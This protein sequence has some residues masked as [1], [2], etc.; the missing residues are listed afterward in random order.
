MLPLLWRANEP[1]EEK[2]GNR[3]TSP[4]NVILCVL[5][6]PLPSALDPRDLSPEAQDLE[7]PWNSNSPLSSG[8]R[9]W[10]LLPLL[11]VQDFRGSEGVYSC[12]GHPASSL[13][14]HEMGRGF[15]NLQFPLTSTNIQKGQ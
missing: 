9:D 5:H 13:E 12:L 8:T 1:S 3:E 7:P 4:S 2:R 11:Y 10:S 15:R 6:N 14:S